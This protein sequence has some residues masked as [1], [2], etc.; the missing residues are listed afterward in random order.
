MIKSVVIPNFLPPDV[1]WP[2][3][4]IPMDIPCTC[5]AHCE[6]G[7]LLAILMLDANEVLNRIPRDQLFAQ[8]A[9]LKQ[10]SPWAYLVIVG[11]LYKTPD[12]LVMAGDQIRQWKWSAVRGALLSLQ[13]MGIS[14]LYIDKESD[15]C[16]MLVWLGKRERTTKRALAQR[17]IE[18]M[19]PAE[20]L[21]MALPGIGERHAVLVLH[22]C[23]S[24]IWALMALTDMNSKIPGIGS[25]TIGAIR[26]ALGLREDEQICLI[27]PGDRIVPAGMTLEELAA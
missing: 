21:L 19:S 18:P 13:E 3:P 5:I 11:D 6:D 2:A 9:E 7:S 1:A 27:N 22:E 8:C 10:Q 12:G 14:I 16:P 4:A 24:P 17:S 20:N 25:K 26:E 23:G 15:L